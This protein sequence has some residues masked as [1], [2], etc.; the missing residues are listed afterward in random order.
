MKRISRKGSYAVCLL[1]TLCGC[2]TPQPVLNLAGRGVAATTLAEAELQR[3]LAAAQDVLEARMAIVRQLATAEL[4]ESYGTAF[5]DYLRK[6]T[7]DTERE[8]AAAL[9]ESLGQEHR[10]LR[11]QLITESSKI[12]ALHVKIVTE[13]TVT[14]TDAAF[15]GAKKAFSTLAQELTP[16]EWLELTA[17]Y[18][19]E[20]HKTVK[21]IKE[22]TKSTAAAKATESNAGT[23]NTSKQ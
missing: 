9:I 8:S 1:I 23:T 11:E 21:D 15:N 12:E 2:S 16:Q 14:P 17:L 22:Q 19:R 4:E 10:R 13:L 6:R 20:I 5:A 18:A 7:G 3:Y